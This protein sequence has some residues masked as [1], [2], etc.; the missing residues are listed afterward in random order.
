M[1]TLMPG[2]ATLAAVRAKAAYWEGTDHHKFELWVG[3]AFWFGLRFAYPASLIGGIFGAEIGRALGAGPAD[4][5]MSLRLIGA[6]LG[7]PIGLMW[8]A[9]T[10]IALFFAAGLLK[11]AAL[12]FA[13]VGML[14]LPAVFF[15]RIERAEWIWDVREAFAVRK[16]TAT[17]AWRLI[18]SFTAK[19]PVA[20]H[21]AWADRLP[22][23]LRTT[24]DRDRGRHRFGVKDLWYAL[25]A[26]VLIEPSY[27]VAT[28][29]LTRYGRVWPWE[30]IWPLH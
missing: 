1:K 19:Y 9:M 27:H 16:E 2:A 10:V 7:F 21:A 17:P 6:F 26:A 13:R 11:E 5:D 20:L 28:Y 25:I 29:Y 24:A 22:G 15:P 12:G 23:W 18:G 4:S 8:P 14:Y 30:L 3:Y